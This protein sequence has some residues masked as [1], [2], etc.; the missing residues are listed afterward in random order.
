MP[1]LTP[2]KIIAILQSYDELKSYKK[3]AEKHGVKPNTVSLHVRK[4]KELTTVTSSKSS[5]DKEERSE[6]TRAYEMYLSNFTPIQVAINLGIDDKKAL[7]YNSQFLRLTNRPLFIKIYDEVG[8]F[9]L[10]KILRFLLEIEKLGLCAKEVATRTGLLLQEL[11]KI[12]TTLA[13]LSR[14]VN[15][16]RKKLSVKSEKLAE[17]QRKLQN[18]ELMLSKTCQERDAVLRDLVQLQKTRQQ[19]IELMFSPPGR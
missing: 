1:T 4:A 14:E 16:L 8:Y 6:Q 2:E 7:E 12:K 15:E 9:G 5:S 11:P 19:F 3:V 18:E 10:L 13:A 17:V